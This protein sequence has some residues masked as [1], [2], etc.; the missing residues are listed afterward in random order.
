M[1]SV[2]LVKTYLA[3]MYQSLGICPEYH[4]KKHMRTAILE[5]S[6]YIYIQNEWMARILAVKHCLIYS[7][8]REQF[9]RRVVGRVAGGVVYLAICGPLPSAVW[10]ESSSCAGTLL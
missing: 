7:E 9:R 10:K 4:T 2:I 8:K 6:L 3:D 1:R 5:I